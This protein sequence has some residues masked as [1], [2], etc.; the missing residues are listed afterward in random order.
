MNVLLCL[1]LPE[2]LLFYFVSQSCC[3][4]FNRKFSLIRKILLLIQKVKNPQFYQYVHRF[5]DLSFVDNYNVFSAC[6][7]CRSCF[8]CRLRL[9]NS[10]CGRRA[11]QVLCIHRT[12]LLRL[13]VFLPVLKPVTRTTLRSKLKG[14]WSGIGR[15]LGTGQGASS[16]LGATSALL[17]MRTC[18]MFVSHIST[19]NTIQLS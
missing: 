16:A 1:S 15:C 10:A 9:Q 7:S 18:N 12:L 4:L 2:F 11:S 8:F 14:N 6:T 3:M 19:A 13:G 17:C 5:E